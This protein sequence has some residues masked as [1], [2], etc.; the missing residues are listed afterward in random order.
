M[1][2]PTSSYNCHNYAFVKSEGGDE[3]WLN[4]PGD[5]EFWNDGSYISTTN[6]SQQNLKV[7]YQGDHSAVTTSTPNLAISKWGSWG[8]Y[9][10]NIADVPSSYLPNLTLTYYKRNLPSISGP[11]LVCTS[12]RTFTVQNVPQGVNV[13][14]SVSPASLFAVDTGTGNSF[15]TRAAFSSSS[16]QGTVTATLQ[17]PCGNIELTKDV[18]M[19]KPDWEDISVYEESWQPICPN[20][21]ARIRASLPS[22]QGTVSGHEWGFLVSNGVTIQS[23]KYSNPVTVETPGPGFNYFVMKVKIENAEFS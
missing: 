8:L 17:G 13:T 19:G 16:G 4:T 14:W 21:T 23:G 22:S 9:K 1:A 20:S 7:S 10:H 3:F 18:W 15:A 2:E 11:S 5:D 12:N 6:I